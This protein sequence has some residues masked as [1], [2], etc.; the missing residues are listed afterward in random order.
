[1]GP[2]PG[3]VACHGYYQALDEAGFARQICKEV[4]AAGLPGTT[5]AVDPRA[6]LGCSLNCPVVGFL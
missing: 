2:V 5:C 1:M 6:E 3:K 4:G